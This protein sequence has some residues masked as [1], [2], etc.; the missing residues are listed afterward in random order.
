M[1]FQVK[2]QVFSFLNNEYRSTPI[3]I[4]MNV[5]QMLSYTYFDVKRAYAAFNPPLRFPVKGNVCIIKSLYTILLN[6]F[7]F[8]QVRYSAID[9]VIDDNNYPP[10]L[11]FGKY[12]AVIEF[13]VPALG[14]KK[15]YRSVEFHLL[16][17]IREVAKFPKV[18]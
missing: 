10:A 2:I 4:S 7:S 13:M 11:P 16:C 6:R 12:K 18:H 1:D 15:L 14:V 5:K 3:K 17:E 8:L 9:Y